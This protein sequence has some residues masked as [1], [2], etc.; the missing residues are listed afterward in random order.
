[1][2]FARVPAPPASDMALRESTAD[3]VRRTAV[4]S[5]PA[6]VVLIVALVVGAGLGALI[7]GVVVGS[8][9]GDLR[10]GRLAARE[11]RELWREL[12]AH[13]FSGPR[14]PIYTRPRSAST[15]RT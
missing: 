3:T 14:R 6:L 13:P 7:A 11:E 2:W 9:L 12:G 10:G 8:A 5:A 1:G 4:I 15:L